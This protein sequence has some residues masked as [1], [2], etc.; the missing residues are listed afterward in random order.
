MT[1]DFSVSENVTVLPSR[2]EESGCAHAKRCTNEAVCMPGPEPPLRLA[3]VIEIARH[4][5]AQHTRAEQLAWER[6][7]G[8]RALGRFDDPK[9]S[10]IFAPGASIILFC[11]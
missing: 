8:G 6:G 5:T 3:D 7:D 9:F 1:R 2:E 4:H 10:L 11:I